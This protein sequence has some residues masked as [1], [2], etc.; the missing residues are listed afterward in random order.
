[1]EMGIVYY[2]ACYKACLGV[3][4]PERYLDGSCPYFV[5]RMSREGWDDLGE[6]GRYAAVYAGWTQTSAGVL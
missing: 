1:M 4:V 5:D 3:G 6:E 2:W